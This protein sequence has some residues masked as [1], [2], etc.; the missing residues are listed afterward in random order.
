MLPPSDSITTRS[1][2]CCQ[3]DQV[4]LQMSLITIVPTSHR[5]PSASSSSS[6]SFFATLLSAP[7]HFNLTAGGLYTTLFSGLPRTTITILQPSLLITSYNSL[8]WHVTW[9]WTSFEGIL[10]SIMSILTHNYTLAS[11]HYTLELLHFS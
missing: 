5:S 4:S 11:G 2:W 3:V 1:D 10:I 8:A 9:P 6:F 7:A